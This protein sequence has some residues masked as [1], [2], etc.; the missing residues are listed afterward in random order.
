MPIIEWV[1]AYLRNDR[2]GFNSNV[3]LIHAKLF[4]IENVEFN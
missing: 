3:V 1:C 2:D 4:D